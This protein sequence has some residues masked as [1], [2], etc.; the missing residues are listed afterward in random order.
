MKWINKNCKQNG[1]PSKHRQENVWQWVHRNQPLKK[2]KE[3]DIFGVWPSKSHCQFSVPIFPLAKFLKSG[4]K[5][6]TSSLTRRKMLDVFAKHFEANIFLNHQASV[7]TLLSVFASQ[8]GI[9]AINQSRWKLLPVRGSSHLAGNRG[10]AKRR[11]ETVSWKKMKQALLK[12]E[13][14]A[15]SCRKMRSKIP[16]PEAA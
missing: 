10:S 5:Q 9:H 14:P 11:K 7:Q 4:N 16:R 12:M 13:I 1:K 8:A 2:W 3:M 15:W 6:V